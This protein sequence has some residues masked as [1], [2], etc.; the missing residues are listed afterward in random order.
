MAT[1][2]YKFNEAKTVSVVFLPDTFDLADL[3]RVAYTEALETMEPDEAYTA[4]VA[5]VKSK[6]CYVDGVH[7]PVVWKKGQTI[8]NVLPFANLRAYFKDTTCDPMNPLA[9][10]GGYLGVSLGGGGA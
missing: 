7:Y 3:L 1:F 8:K 5:S 4:A 6:Y 2:S 10:A 9:L